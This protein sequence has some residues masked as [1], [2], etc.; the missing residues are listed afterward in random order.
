MTDLSSV[1]TIGVSDIRTL[2]ILLESPEPAITLTALDSLTKY[3][4]QAQKNRVNLLNSDITRILF[5]R[6]TA[7]PTNPDIKRASIACF[8]ASTEVLEA[9]ADMKR[10]DV[11]EG[12]IRLLGPDESVEVHDE[13]AF[14]L[15]NCAKD[16][17]NKAMIRKCGGIKALFNLLE[18]VDPDVKKNAAL[19][20]ASVLEDFSNRSEIRYLGGLPAIVE[21]LSSEFREIQSNALLSVIR[22]AEDHC[23]RIE[24]R[25]LYT[26]KKI[27]DLLT[28]EMQEL[29]QLCLQA[30]S[31]CLEDVEIA[32]T[33]SQ[34]GCLTV[35]SKFLTS[36]DT[37]CRAYSAIA[38]AKISKN[39][40]N[41]SY[42]RESGVVPA[43]VANLSHSDCL[44][45]STAAMAL[46]N[47]A[48]VEINQI[49]IA[50]LGGIET[51]VKLL[52]HD[53]VEVNRQCVLALSSTCLNS[54]V[55][56][57]VKTLGIQ[58]VVDLLAFEDLQVQINAAECLTNLAEDSDIRVEL[59][60]NN[61][62]TLLIQAIMKPDIKI[63]TVGAL[64]LARCLNE[65]ECRQVL[66]SKRTYIARIVE[67]L[68]SKDINGS[69]NAAL[70]LSNACEYEPNALMACQ[71]GAIDAMIALISDTKRNTLRFATDAL[72]NLLNHYLP[73]KYWLSNKLTKD[74]I[75]TDG[76]YDF[77]SVGSNLA[78]I[79]PFPSLESLRAYPI[80]KKREVIV[81]DSGTDA[82][83]AN[84]VALASE[85][86]STRRPLEQ[87]QHIAEIV[88]GALGGCVSDGTKVS[89][90]GF[91]VHITTLKIACKS[92]VLPI[93]L[94][95]HGTFYHRAL[96]FK[97][98][99]DRC[100]LSPVGVVRGEYN[101]GWNEIA[102]NKLAIVLPVVAPSTATS[103]K[104]PKSGGGSRATPASGTARKG[105]QYGGGDGDFEAR[106]YGDE[107]V[108]SVVGIVDLMFE[109]GAI[110]PTG[111]L[112]AKDY[113][114]K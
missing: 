21:L 24:F 73:A 42:I 53:N 37:K 22:C 40:R 114:R 65:H 8:A 71:M 54:K 30:I 105:A 41:H 95:K 17:G 74:N 111:S 62:V 70:A 14:A 27:F 20:L 59:S 39:P 25:K 67:L 99:A 68:K 10:K 35:I 75:I 101:R 85:G 66:A 88:V 44:V 100:G 94:I 49:E 52:S 2:L 80:D 77:G 106:P 23:N 69:R 89:D 28:P 76:F 19:A 103:A 48:K 18:S 64:A 9:H 43:L 11:I 93:G 4:E 90:I 1:A 29:H 5:K 83:F 84:L 45:I 108:G 47:L 92:N 112:V 104:G 110:L 56:S 63:Q 82:A 55:R 91:K 50:R 38:I 12:L 34:S 32:S 78:S 36:D 79:K 96:L 16:F 107:E 26:V 33:F 81:I 31:T 13:A 15:A 60:K 7:Q 51:L 97:A 109:A 61:G 58:N 86:L 72:E 102:V 46:V 6:I 3:A 87:V 98:L 57:R 113:M